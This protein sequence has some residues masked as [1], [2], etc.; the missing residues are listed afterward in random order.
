MQI[1]D[2]L[3][4]NDLRVVLAV[5]RGETLSAAARRL[6][7]DQ[8]TVTR[9]LAAVERTVGTPLFLRMERRLRPTAAGTMAI[10]HAERVEAEVNRLA[11]QLSGA[12]RAPE[13]NVRLTA[14]PVVVNRL[15]LPRLAAFRRHYPKLSLEL[16][17]E[18]RNLQ[19]AKRDADIAVRLARP[20]GGT[21]L[22]R[23]LGDLAYSV[24]GPAGTGD[25]L[26]WLGYD[27]DH[28]DLPQARWLARGTRSGNIALRANDA[29]TL[30]QAVAAGLGRTLLPD[31][32]VPDGGGLTRLSDGPVLHREAWLLVHPESRHLPRISVVVDWLAELFGDAT[33]TTAA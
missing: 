10:A 18:P 12:D 19:L 7:V 27:D 28:A 33:K 5:A 30:F 9:R 22:C 16:I 1:N 32:A 29:E 4:W 2:V 20:A 6:G 25:D 17:A 15:L 8:T 11:A 14:V 24:Y 31:L 3:N 13:G 26:P 23:K 21:A